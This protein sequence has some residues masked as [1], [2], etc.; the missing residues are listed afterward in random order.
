MIALMAQTRRKIKKEA[1]GS[2]KRSGIE[3]NTI[4][5]MRLKEIGLDLINCG[6]GGNWA[7][8]QIIVNKNLDIR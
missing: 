6:L 8:Q 2:W 4:L 1:K 3:Q 5:V 7:Q